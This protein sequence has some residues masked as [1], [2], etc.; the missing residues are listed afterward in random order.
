MGYAPAPPSGQACLP[1]WLVG[2]AALLWDLKST[3]ELLPLSLLW[4][5]WKPGNLQGLLFHLKGDGGD[6]SHEAGGGWSQLQLLGMQ[7]PAQLTA[8]LATPLH[9]TVSYDLEGLIWC[10]HLP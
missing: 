10:P 4:S 1:G 5:T 6:G 2:T 7:L 9:R 3:H 8:R